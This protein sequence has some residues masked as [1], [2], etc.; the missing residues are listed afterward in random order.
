MEQPTH[1]ALPKTPWN[2]GKLVA[3]QM[4]DAFSR[5]AI[6]RAFRRNI[7]CRRIC[8]FSWIMARH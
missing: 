4:V 8:M 7:A 3:L 6:E 5:A 2:K 1:V